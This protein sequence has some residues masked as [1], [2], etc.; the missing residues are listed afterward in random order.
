MKYQSQTN[1]IITAFQY[2]EQNIDKSFSPTSVYLPPREVEYLES[3]LKS[4]MKF[5]SFLS[6]ILLRHKHSFAKKAQKRY[7]IKKMIQT[8]KYVK[9]RFCFR[10]NPDD[11]VEVQMLGLGLGRSCSLIFVELLRMEMDATMEE[12]VPFITFVAMSTNNHLKPQSFFFRWNP[13]THMI[14]KKYLYTPVP[15]L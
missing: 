3:V 7:N 12:K 4:G 14:H 10:P 11:W 15:D 1:T 5:R 2:D 13:K 9:R 6:H 8:N